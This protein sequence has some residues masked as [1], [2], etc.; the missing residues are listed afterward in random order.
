MLN[1][2]K[3][4]VLLIAYIAWSAWIAFIALLARFEQKAKKPKILI[5]SNFMRNRI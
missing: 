5:L 2:L 4:G 1:Y 3:L